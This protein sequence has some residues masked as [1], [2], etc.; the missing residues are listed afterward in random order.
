MATGI[1]F[2][3]QW[4]DT[5]TPHDGPK[6]ETHA[7]IVDQILANPGDI[8]SFLLTKFRTVHQSQDCK[9]ARPHH[10]ARVT[11]LGR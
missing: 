1:Y 4:W 2:G 5:T 11:G 7:K 8:P 6:A 9:G 10:V 3:K